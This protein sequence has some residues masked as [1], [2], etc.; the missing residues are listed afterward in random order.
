[1]VY[2]FHGKDLNTYA[3]KIGHQIFIDEKQLKKSK[4][5]KKSNKH[6]RNK[7][8]QNKAKGERQSLDLFLQFRRGFRDTFTKINCNYNM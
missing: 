5:K 3:N 2:N 6:S 4:K 1:M 7:S 8:Q